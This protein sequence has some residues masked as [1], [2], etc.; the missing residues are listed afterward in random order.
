ME[1]PESIVKIREASR[2]ELKEQ[3]EP[4]PPEVLQEV[5]R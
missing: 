5:T 4:L 1:I 3:I 2:R